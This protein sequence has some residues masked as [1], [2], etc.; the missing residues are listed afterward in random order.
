MIVILIIV[1]ISFFTIIYMW[2]VAR[3]NHVKHHELFFENLPGSF[4]GYTIFFIADVHRRLIDD[5]II[6]RIKNKANMIIIGGD[7]TEKGVPY[8]RTEENIQKL[9]SVAPVIFIW[10]NNDYEVNTEKLE[11]IFKRNHVTVL[12]NRSIQIKSGKNE[13]ICITGFSE[14]TKEEPEPDRVLFSVNKDVFKIAVC[15]NPKIVRKIF[16]H[17]S[18][19]LL[20]CGHTHGGQIRFA[21]FGWYPN[22]KLYCKNNMKILVTNG[23]GTTKL[24]LRLGSKPETHL[25]T[26]RKG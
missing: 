21:G 1:T 24:P 4:S 9:R 19:S 25:I 26:L 8:S 7:L 16:N 13:H 10:G 11:D 5:E 12:E 17:H 6:T 14:F 20:L 22:G 15:H 3:E 18:I 23:Y 2:K